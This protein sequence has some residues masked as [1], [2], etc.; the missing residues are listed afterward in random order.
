MENKPQVPDYGVRYF[1]TE[2]DILYRPKLYAAVTQRDWDETT[3]ILSK[4]QWALDNVHLT[5]DPQEMLDLI[6][7]LRSDILD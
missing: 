2:V 6:N 7:D 5:S 4:W 3:K 1:L